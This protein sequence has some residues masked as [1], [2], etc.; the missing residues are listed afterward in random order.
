MY[1]WAVAERWCTGR[2][3][4]GGGGHRCGSAYLIERKQT[5]VSMVNEGGEFSPF[6]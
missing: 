3:R 2:G 4:I 6:T 5:Q 1:F